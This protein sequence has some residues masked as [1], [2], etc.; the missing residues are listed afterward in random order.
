MSNISWYFVGNKE[1]IKIGRCAPGQTDRKYTEYLPDNKVEQPGN[2][3]APN[4][5]HK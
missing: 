2:S 1:V 3:N 4:Q 5:Q